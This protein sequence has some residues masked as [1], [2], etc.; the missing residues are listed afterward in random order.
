MWHLRA[1]ASV[2]LIAAALSACGG[3]DGSPPAIAIPDNLAIMAPGAAESATAVAFGSSVGAP[4][5]LKYQW[6]F[7]DGSTSTE[8][9]PS[10]SFARGGDYDV[11]LKVTNE[12]GTSRETRT[13]ISVTNVANV[14]GLECS[15]AASTGWCWQRPTPT[16]NP[17]RAV[18]FV[19]ASTGWR[20]GDQG[21]IFKTTDG[22]ATWV[23]QSSGT[24]ARIATIRLLDAS[25]GWAVTLDGAVLRTTDG[26]ARWVIVKAASG[27]PPNATSPVIKVFDTKTVY[28][29]KSLSAEANAPVELYGT[30]DGGVTWQRTVTPPF[31]RFVVL[32]AGTFLGT[33][34]SVVS[35]SRDGGQSYAVA[36]SPA[37]PTGYDSIGPGSLFVRDDQRVAIAF[38]A[39]RSNA[40]DPS[41]AFTDSVYTTVDA[42][43]HWSG[44]ASASHIYELRSMSADAKVL[45]G[46]GDPVGLNYWKPVRSTDG[47]ATWAKQYPFPQWDGPVNAE[48]EYRSTD[49]HALVACG[50]TTGGALSEDDGQ[51]WTE[52]GI[53]VGSPCNLQRIDAT[54]MVSFYDAIYGPVSISKDHGRTWTAITESPCC[55]PNMAFI[56]AK[57]GFMTNLGA[58]FTT[59]DG[60][61]SWQVWKHPFGVVNSMQLL[62]KS[63]FWLVDG[64]GRLNKSTDAG[65]TWTAVGTASNLR[66]PYFESDTLGFAATGGT[67]SVTR[68]GGQTWTRVVLPGN[69][70]PRVMRASDQA[71]VALGFPGLHVSTDNGGSWRVA[72]TSPTNDYL[73]AVTFADAKTAWAVGESGSVLK[74]EDA[75]VTWA[76]V[77][78]PSEQGGFNFNDVKFANA[79]VGWIVGE[80][81]RP[82]DVGGLILATRDGGKTWRRQASGTD[83]PLV[84]IQTVDANTAWIATNQGGLLAT[85]TG[86]N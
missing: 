53:G 65:Q 57:N 44:G 3:G 51:T 70:D 12:A 6:D 81:K 56:D 72:Y 79:K 69:V 11:V 64:N 54:T 38:R 5:G 50:G 77:E 39:I 42:G 8:A 16:G 52:L 61:A 59:K 36:L 60:G 14:R 20:G 17:I 47:G 37:V 45:T 7:G 74:S 2:F 25:T 31:S 41:D 63:S 68:D 10:H 71:W 85:G 18:S 4:A 62:N 67:Y 1:G 29:G 26:G 58:S 28:V 83:L 43:A 46:V 23:R 86:G 75:G 82:S 30:Q 84:K 33:L 32:S 49:W 40:V 24:T 78:L 27:N 48:Y 76:V 80:A 21:E 15:G 35:V 66:S 13:T 9:A 22:G 55:T 34:G 73:R 19:S